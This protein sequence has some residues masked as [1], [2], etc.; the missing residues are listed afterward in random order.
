M[1]NPGRSGT[2]PASMKAP[3][4]IA[5]A[6]R[7]VRHF[8]PGDGLHCEDI[9]VRGRLHDWTI[10]AHRHE[11]LHQFML[12]E[13]GRAEMT[14]DQVPHALQAP[15]V[16]MVPP[17]CV[18]ALRFAA[19]S[20]GLQVTVPSARL[21]RALAATPV[22]AARLAPACVLQGQRMA[23]QAARAQSLFSALSE[24]FGGTA[25]GRAEALQAHLLLLATWLLREAE[26]V[27]LD[28]SRGA[29]RDTLAQRYR[30]LLERHLRQHQPL[31]FYAAQ[32]QVTPDHLSRSCR[33]A[34]GLS[35]LELLHERMLLEARRLLAYTQAPVAEV[36]RE[37]GFEDPAYFSRFFARR[38]GH[39]PQSYRT[40]LRGGLAAPP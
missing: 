4:T 11:G 25:P 31:G 28:R 8:Q 27:H 20:A 21:A 2:F 17:G 30:A 26:A 29:L 6:F 1:D 18:H 3:S 34:T 7:E 22:L 14:L 33:A 16:L 9:A 38:A 40:T 19:D 15:A 23:A 36:A 10:P 5:V 12:L 13:R 35:A 39:S 37:L 32:L 24:E